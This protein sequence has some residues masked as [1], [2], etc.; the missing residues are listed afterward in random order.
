MG[1]NRPA[2]NATA[3]FAPQI[4][5]VL[6]RAPRSVRRRAPVLAALGLGLAACAAAVACVS[7][8]PGRA[9]PEADRAL[10]AGDPARAET[11]FRA[12]AE[13][14]GAPLGVQAGARA[15][16]GVALARQGR[17]AEAAEALE[18][19]A[20]L[21]PL[22]PDLRF[23][24]GLAYRHLGRYDEARAQYEQAARLAPDDVEIAYNLGI[25][26]E[27]YLN[28]PDQAL[29]AYRR[30]V[31]GGGHEAARVSRWIEAIE[32]RGS[33]ETTETGGAP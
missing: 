6:G 23:D 10:R 11:L 8:S 15:N 30:Y 19:A 12:A 1:Y 25:L 28:Q 18:A 22:G 13:A 26:Y 27:V 24:L 17:W 7:G 9:L 31:A 14:E 16:L 2:L 21:A 5:R 32:R 4:Q 29:A 20:A 33:A 3:G